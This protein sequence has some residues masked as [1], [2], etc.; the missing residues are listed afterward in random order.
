MRQRLEADYVWNQMTLEMS[1]GDSFFLLIP[2]SGAQG[3]LA[4][5]TYG[6]HVFLSASISSPCWY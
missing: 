2:V 6:S 4:L 3:P 1:S 5:Q